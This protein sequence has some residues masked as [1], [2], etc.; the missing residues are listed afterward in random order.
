LSCE[1]T[2]EDG[3]GYVFLC[4]THHAK[5][6]KPERITG[7]GRFNHE[8]VA[9]DPRTHV[10]YLTEDRGDGCLYR[11]VPNDPKRPFEGQLSALKIQGSDGFDT[12]RDSTVGGAHEVVW[13]D[14]PEPNPAEDSVRHQGRELGAALIRRGEGIAEHAGVIYVCSTTG[15]K[16]SSGQIFKLTPTATGGTLELVAESQDELALDCPDNICVTPWGD[17]LMCEDGAGDQYLRGLTPAGRVYDIARN[18]KSGG[19]LAGV[20][21]SPDHKRLFVN[22]QHEG[23]TLAIEGPLHTLR[24]GPS[25]AA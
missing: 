15:G 7:Y 13:V 14:I 6:A 22:L 2:T 21:L 17:I 1:E 9:I 24:D 8:A 5:V 23:L 25:H 10:A 19:E 18:A 11:F 3:H 16:N 12:A 20:C 4:R